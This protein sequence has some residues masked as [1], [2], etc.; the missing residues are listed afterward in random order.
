MFLL[1]PCDQNNL[2]SA[3]M[4]SI[5]PRIDFIWYGKYCCR[6]DLVFAAFLIEISLSAEN[7]QKLGKYQSM[8]HVESKQ[9][10]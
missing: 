7:K 3:K 6:V 5:L 4:S 2:H 9:K 10:C 1:S 8:F